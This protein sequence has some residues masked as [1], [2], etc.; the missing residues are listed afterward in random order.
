MLINQLCI[1]YGGNFP[2]PSV[3]HKLESQGHP[4]A[5]TLQST[6][7]GTYCPSAYY[8]SY[9]NYCGR[10]PDLS[11]SS[12]RFSGRETGGGYVRCLIGL[13]FSTSILS[14]KVFMLE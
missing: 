12:N 14:K 10:G 1:S 6:A 2:R 3:S 8:E 7:V 9:S 5:L 11:C 4:P 13:N